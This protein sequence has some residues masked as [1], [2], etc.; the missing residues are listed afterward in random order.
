MRLKSLANI[1]TYKISKG[2]L[3][4]LEEVGRDFNA[5]RPYQLASRITSI[6][7]CVT[8]GAL[9]IRKDNVPLYYNKKIFSLLMIIITVVY[10]SQSVFSCAP[11]WVSRRGIRFTP[12]RVTVPPFNLQYDFEG[13]SL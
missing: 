8:K 6:Y 9:F 13:S 3:K 10:I 5:C 7:E 12:E 11:M 4:I 1:Q 2:I